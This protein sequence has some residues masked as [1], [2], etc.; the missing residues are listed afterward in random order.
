MK[1]ETTKSIR[2]HLLQAKSALQEAGEVE[3]EG[4][5]IRMAVANALRAVSAPES[6]AELYEAVLETDSQHLPAL[7]ALID[8]AFEA[9]DFG[10]VVARVDDCLAVF[11]N[12]IEL[13][14]R[15][16]EALAKSGKSAQA[17]DT[18]QQLDESVLRTIPLRMRAGYVLQDTGELNAAD[19]QYLKVLADQPDHLGA[20]L[21]RIALASLTGDHYL[22]LERCKNAA[23]YHPNDP[24]ILRRQAMALRNTGRPREA[25]TLLSKHIEGNAG[26]VP[27]LMELAA[28]LGASGD[29]TKAD[30]VYL[31][32]LK[33]N[34]KNR[35]AYLNRINLAEGT[36][37]IDA[38][39]SR[40]QEALSV[41]PDDLQ[42][43]QKRVRLLIRAGRKSEAT[44]DLE[45]LSLE[46]TEDLGLLIDRAHAHLTIGAA[47]T[48]DEFF[49]KVLERKPDHQGAILGRVTVAE[50]LGN[51]E[52][53]MRI[54]EKRLH[55]KRSGNTKEQS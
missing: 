27:V 43:L 12:E 18:V 8:S 37:D 16:A 28:S 50:S 4:N 54:L 1:P 14:L 6:A 55:E 36:S 20:L 49:A 32:I 29:L 9:R 42:L 7:R 31:E 11:P 35:Q 47:E 24:E 30:N 38:A 19:V 40:C 53:A 39:L 41:F 48:A 23:L 10:A 3:A 51:L 21:R 26:S 17:R 34:P 44:Q 33:D 52:A 2:D 25:I 5:R 22:L 46:D 45:R 15:K 13:L